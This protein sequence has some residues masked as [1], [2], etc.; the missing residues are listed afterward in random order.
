MVDE[1]EIGRRQF[2]QSLA[3]GLGTVAV[4]A[5][6]VAAAQQIPP[7]PK[8]PHDGSKTDKPDDGPP[9]P[10]LEAV[11]LTYLAR[12]YPSDHL[13]EAALQGIYRDIRG[14]VARSDVLSSFPLKNS[15]EPA[16]AFRAWSDSNK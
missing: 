16:F 15:D 14:D 6:G 3:G 11:L 12:R 13:D 7:A 9:A 4:L 10:P 5:S 2:A 8:L 1:P